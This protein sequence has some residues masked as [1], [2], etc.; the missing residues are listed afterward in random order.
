MGNAPCNCVSRVAVCAKCAPAI[1]GSAGVENQLPFG[2][3][4]QGKPYLQGW[5]QAENTTD[6]DWNNVHLSLI[7]GRPVSFIQNL[8]SAAL[9]FAPH[10]RAADSRFRL[11][12][13][14]IGEQ[15]LC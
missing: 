14:L 7:S 10:S 9:H 5:A 12:R 4:P 8:V 6:E 3:R 15:L 1:A 2:A 13:R 11:C